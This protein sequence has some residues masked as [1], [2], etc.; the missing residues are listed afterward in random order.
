MDNSI[1][2]FHILFHI[3][4]HTCVNYN[5]ESEIMSDTTGAGIERKNNL[6]PFRMPLFLIEKVFKDENAF[7]IIYYYSTTLLSCL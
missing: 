2:A 4:F 7:L 5:S 1:L 3:L 6:G